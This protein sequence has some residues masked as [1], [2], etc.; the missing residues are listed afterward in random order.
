M[1]PTKSKPEWLADEKTLGEDLAPHWG[2]WG[3]D[4]E[5]GRLEAVLLRRPGEEIE[6]ISDPDEYRWLDVMDPKKAREQHDSLAEE[7]QAFGVS[8]HYVERMRSDRPN[9][10]FMRD[11]VLMTPE[12]AV[13]GRQA[14]SCRRGE[15]RYAAEAL[16]RLGV[17]ILHT[18]CGDGIF[19]TACC[20]WVDSDTVILGSGNRANYEGCRQVE[21]TLA[22]IGVENFIYLQIPYGYAHID[23]LVSFVDTTTALFDPIRLP[24]D[25]WTSLSDLGIRM[26]EAPSPVETQK[27]AL[28]LVALSPGTVILAA[29]FPKTRSLLEKEGISVKEVDVS[30]LRKGWG[31]LHCMTAVLKREA[32]GRII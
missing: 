10:L 25:V 18:V 29:D 21:E 31:S 23:S 6:N 27:L 20:L 15:E 32:V 16:A 12:G 5:V 2:D 24:W 28:N 26:L 13:V 11:N 7:F 1:K 3:C 4:S 22:S 9:A 8:V 17:P 30:E 14:M 19:E